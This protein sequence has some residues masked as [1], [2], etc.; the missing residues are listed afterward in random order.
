MADTK[1]NDKA[2]LAYEVG[3]K[4]DPPLT[5]AERNRVARLVE[6]GADPIDAAERVL[7]ERVGSD[8]RTVRDRDGDPYPRLESLLAPSEQKRR[9]SR[10]VEETFGDTATPTP[11]QARELAALRAA[12]EETEELR[13]TS[14][15]NVAELE[16]LRAELDSTAALRERTAE[17]EAE[18]E[19]LRAATATGTATADAD[20][21]Q[22]DPGGNVQS[23]DLAAV[24]RPITGKDKDRR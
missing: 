1:T 4:I 3:A 21:Q 16:R 24:Q 7:D 6:D 22:V 2:D 11:D 18:N 8:A 20:A 10:K 9:A 15:A 19:R 17:L 5:E 23:G 13:K 12:A 14:E